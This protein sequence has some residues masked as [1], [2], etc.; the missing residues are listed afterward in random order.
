[1]RKEVHAT[2][3]FRATWLRQLHVRISTKSKNASA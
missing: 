3:P 1:M 2:S